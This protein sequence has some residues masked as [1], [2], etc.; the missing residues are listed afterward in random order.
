MTLILPGNYTDDNTL[1]VSGDAPLHII[2]S[3]ENAAKKLFE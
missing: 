2:T 1:F 3:Q